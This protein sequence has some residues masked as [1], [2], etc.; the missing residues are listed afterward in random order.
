MKRLPGELDYPRI[1]LQTGCF[2]AGKAEKGDKPSVGAPEFQS[3]TRR[4]LIFKNAL[5]PKDTSFGQILAGPLNNIRLTQLFGLMDKPVITAIEILLAPDNLGKMR[6]Y[7]SAATRAL[8]VKLGKW[9]ELLVSTPTR[10]IIVHP[11]RLLPQNF[12]CLMVLFLVLLQ[13]K[14]GQ[15]K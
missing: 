10:G 3:A 8:A 11:F 4:E 5:Q 14:E 7:Q 1:Y 15:P 13:R 9:L 6:G 2:K 12:W